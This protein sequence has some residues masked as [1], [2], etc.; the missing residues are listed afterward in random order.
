MLRN[1]KPVYHDMK[2]WGSGGEAPRI[3]DHSM[4]STFTSEKRA[5][6]TYLYEAAK[7]VLI[8]GGEEI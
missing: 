8:L 7:T 2:S 1:S 3:L 6:G 5:R 4:I